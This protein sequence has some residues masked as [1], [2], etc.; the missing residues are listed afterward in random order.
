MILIKIK[1]ITIGL[2]ILLYILVTTTPSK[3]KFDKWIL[4]EHG[5]N[6]EVDLNF[7]NICYKDDKEIDFRSSHFRNTGLFASYEKN[8]EFETGERIT[9]RTLGELGTLFKMNE[10]FWWEILN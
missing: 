4:Q 7:R 3:E 2:F 1:L 10:G 8:Y 6:C 9:I 5:I